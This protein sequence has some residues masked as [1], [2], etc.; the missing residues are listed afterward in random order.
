MAEKE[1]SPPLA[2]LFK[3]GLDRIWHFFCSVRLALILILILTS[4]TLIGTLII[5]VPEDIKA[6]SSDYQLWLNNVAR[7]RFGLWTTPMA[8]LGLFDVF[9][10]LW[11]LG[12][13]SLLMLNIIICT[14]NR[15]PELWNSLK[16]RVHLPD[17]FY[18]SETNRIAFT[19]LSV[20]PQQAQK[21]T[22]ILLRQR[23]YR[24]LEENQGE[25]LYLAADKN[26]YPRLATLLVHSSI[27]LFILGY[28]IGSYWGF[29]NSNFVIPE[30]SVREVGYGNLSLELISFTDEYWPEGPP[31]DYRSEVVIYEGGQEVKRGIIRVNHPLHYNKVS[32]YQSSFGQA[33]A[34]EVKDSQGNVMFNDGVALSLITNRES[35]QRPVG[36][37]SLPG[38][39]VYIISKSQSYF[40]P[41]IEAGQMRV[42]VYKPDSIVPL[43]VKHLD[44]GQPA[45]IEGLTYTF[46]REKRFS[47]LQVSRDPG[48]TLIWISSSLFTLGIS[49]VLLFPHR[50]LWALCRKGNGGTELI[51]RST[52]RSYAVTSELESI[53]ADLEKTL[54]AHR[55]NTEIEMSSNNGEDSLI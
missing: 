47:G 36:L 40:D 31:K 23:R 55:S 30:G 41:L 1:A 52:G 50:R 33:A 4:L 11:F 21:A 9:H 26:R 37:F 24:V 19:G 27:I 8:V 15:W 39:Q 7:S 32:F 48:N 14:L 18:Q 28:L 46:L 45:E 54:S 34:M 29:R 10:S 42:E 2:E 44:P 35:L 22:Q 5:Q 51:I 13:G 6:N 17:A 20:D 25:T 49:L 16:L 53:G 3:P 12:A 43:A 38:Y